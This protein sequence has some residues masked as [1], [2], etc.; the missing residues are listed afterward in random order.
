[1]IRKLRYVSCS[2]SPRRFGGHVFYVFFRGRI[3][4]NAI[5]KSV[6]KLISIDSET[7]SIC[8]YPDSF[9]K[10]AT[11]NFEIESLER[12]NMSYILGI[13]EKYSIG[14]FRYSRETVKL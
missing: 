1:M 11:I 12:L 3:H 4:A 14:T 2:I 9:C 13:Y 6:Q 10:R 8:R 7:Y 5:F